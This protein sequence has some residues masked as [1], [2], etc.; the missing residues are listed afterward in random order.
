[1]TKG[2]ERERGGWEGEDWKGREMEK[3]KHKTTVGAMGREQLTAECDE[4]G[5]G[6]ERD[7]D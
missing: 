3:R 7:Q 6:Q 2:R 5:K 1:M 4:N